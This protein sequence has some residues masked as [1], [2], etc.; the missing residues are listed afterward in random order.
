MIIGFEAKRLFQNFSGLGNYSRNTVNLLSEFYPDNRYVLFAPI[1]TNLY[2]LPDN[3]EVITPATKFSKRFRPYWRLYKVS[4]LLRPN[5]I[6]IYHGLSNVL[7]FGLKKTGVPSV[8]TIHDL[9]FLRFPA[10]YK[11]IDRMLYRFFTIRSCKR[12]T[13]ILAISQQTKNDLINFLGIDAGKIEVVYQSCDKRY[14][15][16]VDETGKKA[17]RQK[18]NLPEKFILCVGTIEQRKNQLAILEGVVKEKLDIPIV[19]V[20]KPTEY[21]KQLDEY[22]IESD[23]RKQMIFL[24][25]TNSAELQAIYQMAGIMVYPSFFEGFGLPVLE[26]QASGCPVI[27]S[28][29]SS[30][31]EAGG[32][33]A[34][35][36]DPGNS[37]E[38]GAAIKKLLTDLDLKN[39]LIQKGFINSR[40]FMDQAVAENLMKLYQSLVKESR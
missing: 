25:K 38:I 22:I 32:D 15:E 27:T 13:K 9:I 24:H 10:F 8:I 3:A 33:A 17:V 39:E 7:P 37:A 19:L 1:L 36:V 31:P 5:K 29:I 34:L 35:Y 18:Y 2:A 21:K 14:Y 23:I 6:D 16:K 28:N 26:A 11:K 4:E 20:G 30:L 40:K 12:A